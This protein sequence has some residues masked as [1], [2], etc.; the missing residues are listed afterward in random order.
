MNSVQ[1]AVAD[2]QQR[3]GGSCTYAGS[4]QHADGLNC[5]GGSSSEG[6]EAALCDTQWQQMGWHCSGGSSSGGLEAALCDT[7]WQ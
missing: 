6:L 7:Q 3:A 4:R 1:A 2:M 5:S